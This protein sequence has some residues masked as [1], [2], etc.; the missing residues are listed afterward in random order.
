MSLSLILTRNM[1][2][3]QK[4]VYV[5]AGLL[6]LN[7]AAGQT[8]DFDR[9]IE[10]IFHQR[11][12]VCH[13]SSQAM[14]GLRLDQKDKALAGGYSGAV[15][16]AGDSASSKIVERVASA[17]EGFRMPPVGERLSDSQIRLLQAWIDAGANWPERDPVAPASDAEG[18]THWSFRPP[19]RGRPPAVEAE[20]WVRNPIDRFVLERL[21]REGITPSAEAGRAKLARRVYLD[22]TGLPPAPEEVRRFEND[23]APGAYER[24]VDQLLHSPH[25]G[26]KQAVFW[27]DAARYADSE[28]YEKDMERPHAWRWRRWVIDALNRDMPFDQFSIEQ[29]AGDL[30]PNAATEQHVATGFLR[31]GVKNRE[32]GVNS[33]EKRFE[34]VLDR[35]NTVGTVWLGLTVG[36]AQCHDHK[37]DPLSQ[38][39]FY[40]MFAVFNNAVERDILAPVPGQIGSYMR[41]HAEYRAEREKLLSE[42]G[43]AEL[44]AEWRRSMIQAMDQPGVNLDWD[45]RV[46]GW[47]ALVDRAEWKMRSDA[48]RLSEIERDEITDYFLRQPGP[49]VDKNED[50][51]AK[52]KA[53]IE[54]LEELREALPEV[55]HAYAM[56]EREAG[57][58]THIALRGDWRAPGLEVQPGAP[59]VLPPLE[60]GDEPA[61]LSFAKWLVSETNPLTPRVAVNAMWQELFGEGLVRTSNDFGTQGEQPSHPELLDW[62]ATEFVSSGWSRKHMLRLMATS[63]TYRQDSLER[64]DLADRD[65]GNRLLARQNRL[66]LPAE[67]VR[68]A[69]LA[70]SGLL[71]PAVGGRSIRPPQP[72]GVGDLMYSRRPWEVE[73]GPA[74]YRRGLYIWFQRTSPFPMLLNF[75]APGSLVAS[76][77][78][79]RSNTPLQALNLL[80]DPVFIEAAQALAVRVLQEGSGLDERLDRLFRLCLSRTPSPTERDHAATLLDRQREILRDD[81]K[82]LGSIGP[83]LPAGVER[84][85]L[86][87]W[88]GLAHSVI[89][90]DEFITRE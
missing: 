5:V 15:I 60:S 90:L 68:D 20:S 16:V 4:V 89:N 85:D 32:A 35:I 78:R 67:S 63:A 66:S 45:F 37:F 19:R 39:E 57:V 82:S 38:K 18:E 25:Y 69:A 51:K 73:T 30:L 47:L 34:E 3:S 10:P 64:A 22:L 13:G 83:Y 55:A 56:R 12:Y 50:L 8:V 7:S 74:R 71:D 21:E 23:E 49:V 62:L 86:A 70:A 61:R 1:Q 52:L 46:T 31:N 29:L 81:A 80:N 79:Q 6:W 9:D 26:E 41:S 11:C 43:I 42:N 2:V 59:A 54:K 76:V 24:L 87:A 58:A 88:I 28:G 27:L 48:G 84:I 75:D 40:R 77:K 14:S 33:E 17:K 65:A 44:E 53:T 36:C 72:A